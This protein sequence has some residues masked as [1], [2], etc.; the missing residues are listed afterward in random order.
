MG[1][2]IGGFYRRLKV[3]VKA[4]VPSLQDHHPGHVQSLLKNCNRVVG[5]FERKYLRFWPTAK[6]C[7]R[8]DK[9]RNSKKLRPRPRLFCYPQGTVFPLPA[10]VILSWLI[11]DV[12]VSLSLLIFYLIYRD[13]AALGAPRCALM[14][15]GEAGEGN[16]GQK[17]EERWEDKQGKLT[18]MSLTSW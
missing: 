16:R 13:L 3:F 1:F 8:K 17:S 10:Q 5:S 15:K 2:C 14:K 6:P 7:K 12:L 11:F 18:T 9:D 4:L